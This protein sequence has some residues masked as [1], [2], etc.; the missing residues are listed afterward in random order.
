MCKHQMIVVESIPAKRPR[1]DQCSSTCMR[2]DDDIHHVLDKAL[3]ENNV[4]VLTATKGSEYWFLMRFE[5]VT[6]TDNAR[7]LATASSVKETKQEA[8]SLEENVQ[9][10]APR[11]LE[12]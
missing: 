1:R 10:A 12:L 3:L 2:L 11:K 8:L 4:K 7:L 5:R 9:S 6:S